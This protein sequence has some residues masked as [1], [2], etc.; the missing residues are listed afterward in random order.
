M[1][2]IKTNKSVLVFLFAI[3][4]MIVAISGCKANT[5]SDNETVQGSS[6]DTLTE[7]KTT[8]T[9]ISTET[10]TTTETET[11]SETENATETET[12]AE[13]KPETSPDIKLDG[14]Y[15]EIIQN[16]DVLKDGVDVY[17]DAS[18]KHYTV[19]NQN[20]ALNYDLSASESLLATISNKKGGRYISETMDVFVKM[21][22]GKT[23]YASDSYDSP[24]ANVYRYGFYYYDIHIAGQSFLNGF[25]VKREEKLDLS[26]FK[27]K[28]EISR[29]KAVSESISGV[30]GGVTNPYFSADMSCSTN[31]CNAVRIT[32]KCTGNQGVIYFIA[33]EKTGY[34]SDQKAL[35]K[36]I[37]DGEYH[38]YVVPLDASLTSSTGNNGYKDTL[39]G[40]RLNI[41]GSKINTELS[42]SEISLL[43]LED[44]G[45]PDLL[46]DRNLNVY[47]DKLHQV[48]RL[49]A[50]ND[51]TGVEEVGLVTRIAAD[52][53]DKLIVKDKNRR[54]DSLDE[55]DWN[56]AEYVGFDIKNVGVFGYILPAHESCGTL[57]VTLDD[58]YYV[59]KQTAVPEMGEIKAIKIADSTADP[60][61]NNYVGKS[62]DP[63]TSENDFIFG[64]RIYTDESHR[65]ND[66]LAQA[67][68]EREPLTSE[69]IT[70]KADESAGGSFDGYDPLRG[71]YCFTI[72][73][74][75]SFGDA[76]KYHPNK[77]YPLSFTITG[78][79]RD[80]NIYVM[81]Y[82]FTTSL[83]CSAVL[84]KNDMMLPLPIQ[85][86]KNFRNEF[87]EPIFS[88]GDIRYSES[89][90]PITVHAEEV[91]EMKIL[92]L[93]MNWGNYPLKQ[94]SS[95]QFV[96]PY[97][98]MST[99][100]T[101]TNCISN[102]Y[103]GIY[104]QK[105]LQML[106]D[107][108]AM[109]APT[110]DS[111]TQHTA[112][113]NHYFLRY[114]DSENNYYA[115]ENIHNSIESAGPT[116]N[117]ITLDYL[118][119][120]GK[121]K[122]SYTHMEFPQLDENRAFYTMEYEVLED[123]SFKNFARDFTFYSMSGYVNYE[124]L[125]YLDEN[126]ES[127]VVD[128]NLTEKEVYYQ[129]G[130]EC[131]YFDLFKCSS[132]NDYVNTSF[133]VYN[134]QF[135]IGGEAMSP[136]FVVA[137]KGRQA[138]LTLDLEEVTLK[139]GD[140]FTINVIIMPWGSQETDYSSDAPDKNVRDVRE[141]SLLDPLAAT[142]LNS[143]TEII[144]SPFLPR[145]KSVDG[146]SAEFKLSGGENN[147]AFRVYGMKKL[148]A[149]KLYELI[150]GEW[151]LTDV[152][153]LNHPDS[154]ENANAYDG[155][156]VFYDG[157]G[158]FSYAFIADMTG[159]AERTFKVCADDDFSKWPEP[160]ITNEKPVDI[161]YDPSE[162][163]KAAEKT[164]GGNAQFTVSDDKS[165]ISFTD[166]D[167]I[168][169]QY[170]NIGLGDNA[171]G[172]YIV[173]KYRI[174]TEYKDSTEFFQFFIGTES[175]KVKGTGDN[176]MVRALERDG[177]WQV[178]VIDAST[179][180]LEQFVADADGVYR[181]KYLRFDVL[182][183][184]KDATGYVEIK[185]FAFCK[186]IEEIVTFNQD[187]STV[188]LITVNDAKEE[189]F[190][191]TGTNQPSQSD[192][193]ELFF[194]ADSLIA[195]ETTGVGRVELV[196]EESESFVRFFGDG[197]SAEA[198]SMLYRGGGETETGRYIVL[199]Y[200]VSS[201]V[202][203]DF[204]KYFFEFFTS[205]ENGSP[206]GHGPQAD[207]I[208]TKGREILK[209][210]G[211]WHVIWFDI[212]E[213]TYCTTYKAAEDG[214]YYAKFLRF[215]ML[216]GPVIST[217]SYV[218]IAYV[219]FCNDINKALE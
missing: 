85:T 189:I 107:H 83:E 64:H 30:I 68:I 73:D 154:E 1:K 204:E 4:M 122:A 39:R 199:K 86:S 166:S 164:N 61:V 151:K 57:T 41:T 22:N 194:G 40:I 11:A 126:N 7:E 46:M 84:D 74:N 29:Y 158:T 48:I 65:F 136:V 109:S 202:C 77:H 215:D 124:K 27:S 14:E 70:V 174:P 104:Q 214:K 20:M 52:T 106:P 88:W 212:T 114:T 26:V 192:R 153:S 12:S 18:R 60:V 99:G 6:S 213:E 176:F 138:R 201:D 51:V 2:V 128:V 206:K 23:Y 182:N 16:A 108:R 172:K 87:E 45:A 118:S 132:S 72:N 112:G 113:G 197:S 63:Y 216:N 170:I 44:T 111:G 184:L 89:R 195:A 116:Y 13:T 76:M 142:V 55:V 145:I 127:R 28:N 35:F 210:D 56:S 163:A 211:E 25:D 155:Y 181:P 123:V 183:S 137:E 171:E 90:I 37:D 8:E 81:A 186:S 105:N 19:E 93:Y 150:E 178:M 119:D 131:P 32:M 188:T 139:K 115:S 161:Y 78:D 50:M 43:K 66:F 203:E 121:I 143:N 125:G 49:I 47:S 96:S 71:I 180:G 80:R 160:Q 17:Y 207:L 135:V 218:D 187:M 103:N 179:Y 94:I 146:M 190:T 34:N 95:I 205:T 173:I 36:L 198:S 98:H 185:Y 193:F 117:S 152:S 5:P 92:H 208:N 141:N 58:G 62:T 67:K 15:G 69:N 110:F 200:R 217:S 148:T 3:I 157:D 53:V 196:N 75:T 133:I 33:G 219:G 100:V 42:V 24:L 149:P 120:D 129:L 38:T 177:E 54:H 156:S 10:E 21:K 9:A 147:V 97:Y 159:D 175:D 209:N 165:F 31:D 167:T 82:S 162:L 130:N 191:S 168:P 144:E 134:A 59:I 91:V 79:D 102:Q 140:H 169:E 101:E